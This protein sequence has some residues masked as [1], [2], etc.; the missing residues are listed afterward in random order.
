ME[1]VDEHSAGFV[2]IAVNIIYAYNQR[3][4]K[5]VRK[6]GPFLRTTKVGGFTVQLMDIHSSLC[7]LWKQTCMMQVILYQV[8]LFICFTGSFI[9][10]AR[11]NLF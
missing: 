9:D 11:F 10:K 7:F 4:C 3:M 5:E 2:Y 1:M 8:Q 6:L